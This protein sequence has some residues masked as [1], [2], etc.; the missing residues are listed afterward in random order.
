MSERQKMTEAEVKAIL[1]EIWGPPRPKPKPKVVT[2]NSEVIRDAIVQVGPADPN[3]KKSDE[4]M[5]RVRR[6]DWVTVRTDLWE[7]QQRQKAEER[8]HRKIVCRQSI[9]DSWLGNLRECLAHLV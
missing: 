8:L 2:S 9:S 5:V 7:E 6:S 1:Y 3:Y 4:G